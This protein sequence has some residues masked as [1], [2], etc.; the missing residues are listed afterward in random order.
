M[1][2]PTLGLDAVRAW[3]S[4][5]D[6]AP[7]LFAVIDS[8]VAERDEARAELARRN[9]PCYGLISFSGDRVRGV[10]ARCGNC[11][12]CQSVGE[13]GDVTMAEITAY[14]DGHC[15]PIGGDDGR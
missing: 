14:I 10:E 4:Y 8:V 3:I 9:H 7:A 1:A 6:Q 11:G 12:T 5:A 15:E 2:D 13:D